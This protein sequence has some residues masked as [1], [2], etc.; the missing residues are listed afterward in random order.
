[1]LYAGGMTYYFTDIKHLGNTYGVVRNHVYDMNIQSITG[2]GTPISSDNVIVNPTEPEDHSTFV[3]AEINI[4]SW[5][6]V[7]NDI[8]L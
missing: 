5:R 3:A 1:M 4:L 7:S 8:N 6:V 2:Y